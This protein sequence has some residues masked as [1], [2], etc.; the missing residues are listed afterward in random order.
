MRGRCAGHPGQAE[1]EGGKKGAEDAGH[2][3]DL[4]AVEHVGD[5]RGGDQVVAGAVP[6]GQPAVEATAPTE[7]EATADPE[8]PSETVPT[9]SQAE[10][11]DVAAETGEKT[12]A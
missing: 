10:G 12:E 8:S 5:V 11:E 7:A 1:G 6:L 4:L 2:G 9:P 3:S